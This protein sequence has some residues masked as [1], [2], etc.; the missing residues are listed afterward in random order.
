MSRRKQQTLFNHALLTF[1]IAPDGKVKKVFPGGDWSND[2]LVKALE[3][4]L[5]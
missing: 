5:K 1:V 2:E 3:A 4:T